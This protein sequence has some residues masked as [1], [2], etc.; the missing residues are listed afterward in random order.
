SERLEFRLHVRQL[1]SDS[2]AKKALVHAIHRLAEKVVSRGIRKIDANA[3]IDRMHVNQVDA[4]RRIRGPRRQG[5]CQER[6]KVERLQN[7]MS[8]AIVYYV[9]RSKAKADSECC[10]EQA[11]HCYAQMVEY[12]TINETDLSVWR[13]P[14]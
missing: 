11:F 10:L 5:Q 13:L 6:K 8:K 2:A 12:Q 7:E 1:F 9:L 3:R 14:R 4:V